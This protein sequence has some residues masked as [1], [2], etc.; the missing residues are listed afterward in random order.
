MSAIQK[1]RWEVQKI[2]KI[3][4]KFKYLYKYFR[5]FYD[6]CLR[7]SLALVIC[8]FVPSV[9]V[10]LKV[11]LDYQYDFAQIKVQDEQSCTSI[12]QI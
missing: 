4:R 8:F 10:L 3:I 2:L 5:F 7:L 1:N 12:T 9:L 11:Y 6:H